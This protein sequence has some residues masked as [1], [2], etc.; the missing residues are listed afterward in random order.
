MSGKANPKGVNN[1]DFRRKWDKEEFREKAEEREEK[2]QRRVEGPGHS[3]VQPA[4]RPALTLLQRCP[5]D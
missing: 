3:A 2:V 4:G 1:V 5:A